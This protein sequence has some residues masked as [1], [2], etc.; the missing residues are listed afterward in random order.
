MCPIVVRLLL[1]M[2]TQQRLCVKWNAVKSHSFSVMNGVKQGGV[3]SPI[4]YCVYTDEL[5]LK[6]KRTG[7]GQYM[8]T[9]FAGALLTQMILYF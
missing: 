9:S 4:F 5:L 8:D 3:I 7:M 2:Y 6:L 1:F